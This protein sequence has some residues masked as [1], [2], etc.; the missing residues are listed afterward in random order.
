MNLKNILYLHAGAELYGADIVML[1]LIKGLDKKKFNPSVILPNDGPL[2]DKLKDNN[3]Q[4]SVM[5]YPILRRKYFNIK[6][7][8]EYIYNYYKYSKKLKKY[9]QD[10]HIDIVHVNT[11]AVLEGSYLKR[12]TKAK[13]VWHIHEIL[14]KPK[15]ISKFINKLIAKRA[16]EV[17]CVS[18]AVKEHFS[19]ITK[20]KNV[21]VIYN[22]VDN[23][24]FNNANKIDYLKKEFN[25]SDNDVIVGMIGRINAWK[26]QNDFLNAAEIFL[27]KDK[28]TKALIVGGVFEGQE[29]R[30]E[31]LI[32]K[33]KKSR[34]SD[35]II[36]NDFRTDSPNIHNLIDIFVLP[37]TNPDPLPTVVLEAMATGKPVVGYSHGGIC[38]MVKD[39]YNGY[40]CEVCNYK[41]LADKIIML[42]SN[43]KK[44]L[45]FGANSLNRQKEFFS[46]VSYIKNFEKLYDKFR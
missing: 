32:E 38:E 31:E 2:V 40:L 3:I 7:I 43:K 13:I 6:G 29:W 34:F 4:V 37:S 17:V 30:R 21:L 46:L 18:E 41:D 19:K 35:R 8:I 11:S 33:I 15:M 36:L 44:R 14:L 26:G 20:R 24:K 27:E 42:L 39:S 25:I 12:K 45:E 22:G 28:N 5:N 9:V 1:E 16:D 23:K 10:N